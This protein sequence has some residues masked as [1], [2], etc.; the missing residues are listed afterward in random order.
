MIS[1]FLTIL[2][3]FLILG[4][5]YLIGKYKYLPDSVADGL[6]AYALKV[7]VPVLL[8]MAM[9]R[10]DFS[11]AF[12]L[13]MLASF[14][15]GAFFCFFAGIYLSRWF[16]ARRPGESVAVGF[17]AVFSNTLL[18]GFP[19]AQLVFGEIILAPV[20]GI[21]A[22]HASILYTV[23]MTTMEFARQDG[24]GILDTLKAALTSVIANPLMLGIVAGLTYNL[25]GIG[26]FEPVE[27]ALDMIRLTAI[28]VSL[29]GI[30]IA[31]NRYS[32]STE[33]TETLMVCVLALGVHPAIAFLLAHHLFGLDPLFVQAAVVLAAMP[34]G[35]N[36]YIFA[37]LYNRALNLSASVLV[38]GNVLAVFTIPMWLLLIKAI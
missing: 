23:G 31:L 5:G 21:I 30:G 6:N 14:Y 35:M 13:E 19:I 24:R 29:V 10:L 7:G 32:I 11:K 38:I 33:F 37:S 16:W 4:A 17:C 3:V 1:V 36:V 22:L 26:L 25:I 15:A 12:H 9:F 34:P 8:F 2:P 27:R 20:F 28:P 18:I